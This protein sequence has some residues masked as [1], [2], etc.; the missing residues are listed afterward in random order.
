MYRHVVTVVTSPQQ[1]GYSRVFIAHGSGCKETV[2][3]MSLS[4]QMT[5]IIIV[6]VEVSIISVHEAM[7]TGHI[8]MLLYI[9]GEK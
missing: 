5:C 9:A 2:S 6:V 7:H 3:Q 1:D 4:R 8:S